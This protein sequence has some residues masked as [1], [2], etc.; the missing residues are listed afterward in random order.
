MSPEEILSTKIL[1]YVYLGKICLEVFDSEYLLSLWLPS[2]QKVQID[3][4]L[5]LVSTLVF[6]YWTPLKAININCYD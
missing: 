5:H 2:T 3:H 4:I 1:R 6:A